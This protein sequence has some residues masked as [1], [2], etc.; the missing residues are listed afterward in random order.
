MADLIGTDGP[1]NLV[2]TDIAELIQGLG[3]FD[4][5]VGNG[6]NDTIQGA[7]GQDNISGGA[8]NDSINGGNAIDTIDAGDDND[9]VQGGNG[10]DIIIGG[11]G[12]DSLQGGTGQDSISGGLG[13]DTIRGGNAID[14]IDAGDGNDSVVGGNGDD[15]I[16]G[17][18]GNDSLQGGAGR[19]IIDGGQGNDSINGGNA[20]DTI[21]GG[22]G[23]DTIT[24]GNGDDS[25]DGGS[26]NDIITGGA[27]RDTIIGGSGADTIDGG[28]AIDNI[29]GGSGSDT[30]DGGA[31]NDIIRGGSTNANGDVADNAQDN[32][33]GGSGDD[34]FVLTSVTANDQFDI[35]TDFTVG[36]DSLSGF[37]A[38]DLTYV[39]NGNDVDV[40]VNNLIVAK[41]LNQTAAAVEGNGL[42]TAP[43][44]PVGIEPDVPPVNVITGTD[45]PDSLPGTADMDSISGLGGDDTLTGEAASDILEGGEGAD[46]LVGGAAGL[47]DTEQDTLTGGAGNDI[48]VLQVTEAAD[49]FDTITDFT[50]GSD[51]FDLNGL[52]YVDTTVPDTVVAAGQVGVVEN[53]GVIQLVTNVNG[54]N[55][56]IAVVE[57]GAT[58]AQVNNVNN[59]INNV[60]T[61]TA[62][63]DTL[64]GTS[65]SDSISGLGA[66]DTLTGNAASDTLDGGEGADRLVGGAEG[67]TDTE[68]DTLTGGAGNDIFVLQVTAADG[69]FDTITDFAV[70]SDIFDL[71]GL[72][73]VDTTAPDAV[74]AAGQVGVVNNA[75]VIQL[76]TDVN[77]DQVVIA[78]VEGG[79]TFAEVNDANNFVN[80][81]V[82]VITG[83]DNPETLPGTADMD[84]IS[85]LGADDIITGLA[86][87]DTLDGGAGA[88]SLVGGA[89]G[90]TDT[91]QDTLT[92]GAGNDIFVLQV[93]E[94]ADQFDTITDFIFGEDVFDLNGLT[95][96][97]TTTTNGVINAGELGVV[98]NAGV[99]QLV[100]DVNGT[101]V[102]IAVVQGGAS[103]ALVNQATN[104]INSQI[105][106]VEGDAGNNNL[107]GTD[108]IDS[109]SGLGGDDTLTGL[110]ASD[111]LDGGAGAD[112][113]V[114]GAAGPTDTEQD[115]LTGGA[116][117]DIFV[118]QVTEADG[119]FDTITDFTPGSDVFD[120]NGL[121]YVDVTTTNLVIG[122]GQVGVLQ[123]GDIIQLVSNVNGTN[124]VI[125]VVEGD[126]L[127]FAQVNDVNNFINNVITGTANADTLPGT[128]T[129]DIISGLAGNDIISGLAGNDSIDGGT[130]DDSLSGDDG[131]DTLSGGEGNDTLIGGTADTPDNTSDTLSGGAGA[132]VF[133]LQAVAAA[134]QFDTITDFMDGTD[135]LSGVNFADVTLAQEGADVDITVGGNVIARVQGTMVAD[136]TADDFNQLING[137]AAA[138]TLIGAAGDDTINGMNGDSLN[139]AAGADV[140]MGDGGN[141]VIAG[142]LSTLAGAATDTPDNT[143]DTL[144]GGGG[145]DVFVIQDVEAADQFDVIA[146]FDATAGALGVD[147]LNPSNIRNLEFVVN[148]G[149]NTIADLRNTDSGLTVAQFTGQGANVAFLNTAI[150]DGSI[151][152]PNT[153]TGTPAAET[154]DGA[155]GIDSITGNGGNDELNGFGGNDNLQGDAGTDTLIGGMGDDILAGGG[156]ADGAQGM[157]DNMT[158]TLTGGAGNDVFVLQSVAAAGQFD[159]I[160]D[161]GF[162]NDTID[163]NGF[164]NAGAAGDAYTAQV[165]NDVNILIQAG[166]APA[167]GDLVMAIVQNANQAIVNAALT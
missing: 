42:A 20:R 37:A 110:A 19:D 122:A 13:N 57:G 51:V 121:Q 137:M 10:N 92:G 125:A 132:D 99:I 158:D 66:D 47:T 24:G 44:A 107:M 4:I 155:A 3:D 95:Y 127:T 11:A 102:V 129:S 163:L 165:G 78:V 118:L 128:T 151:F 49:Q 166:A 150:A 126:E 135:R 14:T 112:S 161:F 27:G 120:L 63:P 7:T 15:I 32:L 111:T 114:G 80:F 139:G 87:S 52:T 50:V 157:A 55:V 69:Q 59:F 106:L 113:L 58:F 30:I 85:G 43:S 154:L 23:N 60:I 38:D 130:E 67:T 89:E 73:Y 101:D 33:T 162:G 5:L 100:T 26:G 77:G 164:G 96:V 31:G 54:T 147:V 46:S 90:M 93:T 79:A 62:N 6:G 68:Q 12:N 28:N 2:G 29:V 94:A 21:S 105:N 65:T 16:D 153:I 160:T 123:D 98:D 72:T 17:G 133:V 84:S 148:A 56:V 48:F 119:Q 115:T 136:I 25:I 8:G 34:I 103:F 138:D 40:I 167:A 39:Q 108:D 22:E 142:G 74:V 91:E 81:Q 1:D 18:D 140:L 124:V 159:I 146:D 64:D 117:A 152:T 116:G 88:D 134:D 53:A 83:T 156:M 82:N 45:G 9:S 97:D 144:T 143:S 145:M 41:L 36:Q 104:F 70:G 149:N 75:G 61:G 86:A 109:I 141:D 35:I 71:N 131:A 76:V